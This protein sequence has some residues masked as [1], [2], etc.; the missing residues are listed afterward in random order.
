MRPI[1]LTQFN[2]HHSE[3]AGV[4]PQV[5]VRFDTPRLLLLLLCYMSLFFRVSTRRRLTPPVW[6]FKKF[7]WQ[8]RCLGEQWKVESIEAGFFFSPS[9][10]GSFS[11][12]KG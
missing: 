8:M 2:G 1:R 12:Q 3:C 10:D 4:E 5:F 7:I 11:M 6:L 9:L